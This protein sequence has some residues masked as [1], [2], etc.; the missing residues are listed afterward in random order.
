MIGCRSKSDTAQIEIA[1]MLDCVAGQEGDG[2]QLPGMIPKKLLP[3]RREQVLSAGSPPPPPAGGE[4]P[5]EASSEG[6]LHR[7]PGQ[8]EE[9]RRE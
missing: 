9:L 1:A 5:G 8:V 4:D 7:V 3:R 2:K 6:R